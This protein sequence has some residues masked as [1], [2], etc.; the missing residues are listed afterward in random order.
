MCRVAT[1]GHGY[2][3][4]VVARSEMGAASSAWNLVVLP[5]QDG[6]T[7]Q[8]FDATSVEAQAWVPGNLSAR[9]ASRTPC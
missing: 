7:L 8:P 1:W 2:A 9:A 6:P 3:R 5:S 4:G